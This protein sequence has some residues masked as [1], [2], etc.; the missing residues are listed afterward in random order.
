M[1]HIVTC[2]N[3]FFVFLH[4]GFVVK[5]SEMLNLFGRWHYWDYWMSQSVTIWRNVN[6][7]PYFGLETGTLTV[8]PMILNTDISEVLVQVFIQTD[9]PMNKQSCVCYWMKT[10]M[11]QSLLCK[12]SNWVHGTKVCY[13]SLSWNKRHFKMC[14]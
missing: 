14:E 2:D 10:E 1:C 5:I 12:F 13:L 9:R 7:A 8:I 3:N 4:S 6:V 11:T